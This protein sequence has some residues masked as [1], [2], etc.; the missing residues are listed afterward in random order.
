VL[1]RVRHAGA[2]HAGFSEHQRLRRRRTG[3]KQ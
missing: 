3:K 1:S 2:R